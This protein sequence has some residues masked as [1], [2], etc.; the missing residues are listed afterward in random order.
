[1]FLPIGDTPNPRFTPWVN[2]ALIVTNVVVFLVFLPE[3]GVGAGLADPVLREYLDA[4]G[5]A[6]GLL[7]A[8]LRLLAS[9]VSEYDLLVFEH[10]YRPIAPSLL[11]AVSAMFLHAGWSHLLGN[12]LFLWIYG[13]N[14]EHHLGRWQYLLFYLVA[15]IAGAL[16]DGMLRPDSPIPT[17][18]ASGAISGV[19]GAYFLWFP[20]NRVRIFVFFFPFIMRTIEVGARWV[21]GFYI[22]I[23]NILPLV[24][25]G[26][27]GQVS[28]GAHLGGFSV[29]LL[30]A[31]LW[32]RVLDR[33]EPG[34][35]DYRRFGGPSEDP[36]TAFREALASGWYER[37]ASLFT[38]LP[39]HVTEERIRVDDKLD[40]AAGLES[41]GHDRAAL[42][43]LER[44]IREHHHGAEAG[45][46]RVAAAR[47][48]LGFE[49]PVEA[50]Q[51]LRQAMT[52]P[53]QADVAAEAAELER[54]I[55]ARLR[56]VPADGWW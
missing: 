21:I 47:L 55:R 52:L 27:A 39:G 25:S 43:V 56:V 50:W 22:L 46:A 14:V 38:R 1:V 16:G 31:F 19:L 45:E 10:G 42:N 8:D 53:L 33:P 40:L 17:V 18:G 5:K 15:G 28:Y 11:D 7:P 26:G 48:L 49:L 29:G 54:Q 23:D 36:V 4:I 24:V 13:D 32:T 30:A 9:S 2:Y 37:A 35:R 6:R 41:E 44:V 51:V 20:A 3:M 12:M 34:V